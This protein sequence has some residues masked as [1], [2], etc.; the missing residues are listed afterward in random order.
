MPSGERAGDHEKHFHTRRQA[1]G[2][3][4]LTK[5]DHYIE[6]ML[7]RFIFF[8]AAR[9]ISRCSREERARENSGNRSKV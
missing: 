1:A 5:A 7:D 2:K 8:L 3:L 6:Q 9:S 4:R